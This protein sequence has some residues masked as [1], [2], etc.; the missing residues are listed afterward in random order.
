MTRFERIAKLK[1]ALSHRVLVLDGAMGTAIQDRNLNAQDFGGDAL[2]GCNEVGA[3][4]DG[5]PAK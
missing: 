1:E 3:S 5:G 4:G 2:E